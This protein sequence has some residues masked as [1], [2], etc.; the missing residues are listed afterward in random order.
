M[1][2]FFWKPFPS[3]AQFPDFFPSQVKELIHKTDQTLQL[4]I[5]HDPVSQR[6]DRLRLDSRLSGGHKKPSTPSISALALKENL[7]GTLRRRSLR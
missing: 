7:E 1:D 5:E 4:L 2:L 3:T 6:L